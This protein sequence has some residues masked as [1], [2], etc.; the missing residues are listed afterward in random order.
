VRFEAFE[1]HIP[2]LSNASNHIRLSLLGPELLALTL[3]H[4]C[5]VENIQILRRIARHTRLQPCKDSEAESLTQKQPVVVYVR[6]VG[7]VDVIIST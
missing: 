6:R 4:V 2:H 7:P 5:A 3:H 1:S